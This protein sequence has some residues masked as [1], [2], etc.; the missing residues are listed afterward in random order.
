MR[1][2]F[3]HGLNYIDLIDYWAESDVRAR[4]VY[5]RTPFCRIKH[6]RGDIYTMDYPILRRALFCVPPPLYQV[7]DLYMCIGI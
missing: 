5:S 3:N 2:G 7:F 4:K 1:Y 6:S